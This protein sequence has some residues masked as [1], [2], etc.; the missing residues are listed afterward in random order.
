MI[1]TV[2]KIELYG[3][4]TAKYIARIFVR[5]KIAERTSNTCLEDKIISQ[6]D[7]IFQVMMRSKKLMYWLVFL[8]FFFKERS[9]TFFFLGTVL[10]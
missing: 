6:W 8:L 7:M 3:L 1:A 4:Q 2:L 5:E 10:I 9:L